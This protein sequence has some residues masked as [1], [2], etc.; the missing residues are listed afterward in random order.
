MSCQGSL[1][2]DSTVKGAVSNRITKFNKHM[3][4]TNGNAEIEMFLNGSLEKI[5]EKK[6]KYT[7]FIL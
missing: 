1:N 6:K 3:R 7:L 5:W 2:C 4:V